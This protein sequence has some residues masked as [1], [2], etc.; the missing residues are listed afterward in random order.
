MKLTLDAETVAHEIMMP[1]Y[2]TV[3]DSPGSVLG[4]TRPE[5]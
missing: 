2:W 4:Q 1:S 5:K 3:V